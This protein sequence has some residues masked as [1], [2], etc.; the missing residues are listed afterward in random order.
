[1]S[2]KELYAKVKEL[3]A[4]DAI[5][6]KFGDNYT[7]V[8]N[9]DLEDFLKG[10]GKKTTKKEAAPKKEEEGSYWPP[11]KEAIVKLLSTLQAKRALT[12]KEAEEVAALL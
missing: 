12:A 4:A 10:F 7:R 3:G 2:R 6:T 11:Y 9:A 5:K 8:S 1:M